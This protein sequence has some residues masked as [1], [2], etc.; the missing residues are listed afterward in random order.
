[1]KVQ[2][3][4]HLDASLP[5]RV[6]ALLR[7]R[8]SKGDTDEPRALVVD[9]LREDLANSFV[10]ADAGDVVILDLEVLAEGN[11]LMLNDERAVTTQTYVA[12]AMV[13]E[14]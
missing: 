11:V 10:R 14:R 3:L 8:T 7:G 12:R 1:L 2:R 9:D 5:L 6:L 13:K 4:V